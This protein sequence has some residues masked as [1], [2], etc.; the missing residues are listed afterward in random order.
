MMQDNSI[1]FDNAVRPNATI[2][3]AGKSINGMTE[4][5]PMM[6]IYGGEKLFKL[7]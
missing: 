5:K 4:G 2:A 3:T 6:K 7:N 1:L